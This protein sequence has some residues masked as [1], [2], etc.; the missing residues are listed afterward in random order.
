MTILKQ[1]TKIALIITLAVSLVLIMSIQ[2]KGGLRTSRSPSPVPVAAILSPTTIP[3]PQMSVSSMD[4]PEGSKMLT[5]ERVERAGS[6]SYTVFITAK[7]DSARTEIL[8]YATNYQ[9][10]SI[11]YNTWSPD[12]VYFFLKERANGLDDYLVFR[13]SGDL[14]VND[15]RALSI[16]QQFKEKVQGYEIEDVTGWAGPTLLLVNTKE[17]AGSGKVSFWF[18]VPSQTFM[19]LGTYFK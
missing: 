6:A 16:Q 19:Q 15:I 9:D 12:L 13:S 5:L 7:A 4:S 11:P 1:A 18:D 8:N 3:L 2:R 14:F 17:A 10:L